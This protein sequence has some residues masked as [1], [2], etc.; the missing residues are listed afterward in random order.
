MRAVFFGAILSVIA[1]PNLQADEFN[2]PD[3]GDT[4][5]GIVSL[6]EERRLGQMFLRS[7]RSQVPT[8]NDPLLHHYLDALLSKLAQHSPLIN[9]NFDLVIT[10]SA[11][12]NAF[13]APGNIIGVNTGL[14]THTQNEGQLASVLAHELAHLS[15]RHYARRLEQQQN[16]ALPFYTALLAS[17]VIAASG[18]ADG[19]LA[20]MSATQAAAANAQLKFSRQNEQEA[21][22]LGIQTL[23]DAGYDPYAASD[24]FEQMLRA[25]RYSRRPPEFLLT[26]PV[27]ESRIADA[28]ARAMRYPKKLA[29]NNLEFHLMRSRVR[30]LQAETPQRAIDV[31]QGELNGNS[32]SVDASQYGLALAYNLA[33]QPQKAHKAL[34]PLLQKEPERLTYRVMDIDIDI[35]AEQYD[36]AIEKLRSGLRTLP[37][38]YPFN[39]RYAEVLMQSGRYQTGAH[40]LTQL[41]RQ[42]KDDP[43]LWYLL[44]EVNGLA[45]DVPGVHEARA[46][47][48]ILIGV[49][50][51]AILQLRNAL[52]LSESSYQTALL[53]E[54]LRYVEKLRADIDRG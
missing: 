45:G 13:A 11:S 40:F 38:Y 23:I 35:A 22:R 53:Q 10:Q 37:N 51:K 16:M 9:R 14:M 29:P 54:R 32:M 21:D 2:L 41:V 36:Q 42:I 34:A 28:R 3:L 12:L 25:A 48:F 39:V 27:T 24:M 8:S 44:A 43:Y 31:F 52:K 6:Q 4:T 46:E 19:G 49:Y 50:D 1:T 47:Y 30:A 26:H 20:A 15:Q 5:S 33:S 18:S 17:L 7:Y